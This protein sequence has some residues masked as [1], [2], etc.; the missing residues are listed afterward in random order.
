M[1]PAVK[2]NK[3][4][5]DYLRYSDG[6]IQFPSKLGICDFVLY[7]KAALSDDLLIPPILCDLRIRKPNTVFAFCEKLRLS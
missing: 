4:N 6:K 5:L 2:C 3:I 1:K 7:L